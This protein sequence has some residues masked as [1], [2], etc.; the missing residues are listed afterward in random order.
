MIR[1]GT[2]GWRGIIGEEFTFHNLRLLCQAIANILRADGNSEKGVVIGYDTRFLSERFAQEAAK[3]F[4]F[5]RVKTYLTRRDVPT[6]ALSYEVRRR[7][8]A[9]GL[10]ITASHNPP[11]YNGVKLFT[12]NGATA[13][14]EFT[15]RVEE[16]VVRVAKEGIRSEY[17][18]SEYYLEE[19]DPREEYLSLLSERVDLELIRK[20]GL[21]I[22]LDLLYGTAREYLDELLL[23][24]GCPL[25]VL[26]NFR[27][28]YFGGYSPESKKENLLELR[29]VL[30]ERDCQLGLATDADSDRFGVLDEGGDYIAPNYILALLFR[31]LLKSRKMKGGVAR[32][33]ATTHLIDAIA[34]RSGI[35]VYETPV[36]FK[37]IGELILED[38]IILGG[39]E[40]AGLSIKGHIPEKDGILACLLVAEMA[41]YYKKKLLHLL[42]DI[43]REVGRRFFQ[44]KVQ[45]SSAS[46][47]EKKVKER[48]S[49]PPS[50]FAR[51]KVVKVSDVDGLKLVFEDGSWFLIRFSGTEPVIRLYA[52]GETP[53]KVDELI[54]FGRRYF[55]EA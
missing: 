24:A 45:I 27:D 37:Y 17:Y 21:K 52:E 3:I 18:L 54:D 10:N 39:E 34:E 41:S 50:E 29:K 14:P 5:N 22:A 47:L 32:S 19:I 30:R 43:Y 25:E 6:P 23:E 48:M 20:S 26:H 8:T 2:S 53:D 46:H 9:L 4:T 44:R 51:R 12:G 11:E 13:L 33:V 15:D 1:F 42:E 40:S 16:E 7:E 49:S 38:K 35:E 28:P 36:G 31:Y 55:L